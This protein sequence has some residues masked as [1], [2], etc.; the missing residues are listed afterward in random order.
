MGA[1]G[2]FGQ[3][4]GSLMGEL[5]RFLGRRPCDRRCQCLQSVAT[6]R[7]RLCVSVYCSTYSTTPFFKGPCPVGL[8]NLLFAVRS[9]IFPMC[10][11]WRSSPLLPTSQPT[12]VNIA[13][14]RFLSAPWPTRLYPW[15]NS[16]RKYFSW[17]VCLTFLCGHRRPIISP[18]S[19]GMMPVL[20][21]GFALGATSGTAQTAAGARRLN[22]ECAPWVCAKVSRL[23]YEGVTVVAPMLFRCVHNRVKAKRPCSSQR[24]LDPQQKHAGSHDPFGGE[25]KKNVQD[26][27]DNTKANS[28]HQMKDKSVRLPLP[29]TTSVFWDPVLDKTCACELWRFGDL[30]IFIFSPP[31]I[32]LLPTDEALILNEEFDSFNLDLWKHEITMVSAT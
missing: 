31:L 30:D 6:T 24:R 3:P 27:P 32:F 25:S 15:V 26:V 12:A 4:A 16:M 19:S 9:D 17:N 7:R 20:L 5:P 14:P 11:A 23:D 22:G 8:L 29:T 2:G 1:C 10:V 13:E 21:A 28:E 18:S